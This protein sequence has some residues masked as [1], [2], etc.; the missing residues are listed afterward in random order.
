MVSLIKQ[1]FWAAVLTAALVFPA[2][3]AD[4]TEPGS[5][6]VSTGPEPSVI[7]GRW[8]RPDGG[9]ILQLTNPGPDG[10]L[11][12]AYFNP[13]PVHVSRAAWKHQEGV[14]GVFVELRAPNYPGSTYLL[15]YDAIRDR[16]VGIYFQAAIRQ[17]FE[18]EFK[19]IP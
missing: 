13:R 16:L 12:G 19:R 18:V 17:Q 3:A 1:L 4:Q 6:S 5:E 14:L 2:H 11:E 10:R 9:Y 15:A 8:E 7:V